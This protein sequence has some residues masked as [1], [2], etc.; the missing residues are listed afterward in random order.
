MAEKINN[1]KDVKDKKSL[2]K[3]NIKDE[4]VLTM[5]AKIK[6]SFGNL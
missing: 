2:I 4:K 3:K 6:M 5:K 1:K